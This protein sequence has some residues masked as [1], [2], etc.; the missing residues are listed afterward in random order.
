M[1]IIYCDHIHLKAEDVE[2]TA[3]WYRDRL[4]GAITYRGEFRGSPVVYVTFGAFNLV[5]YGRLQTDTEVPPV[6]AGPRYGI[7]HFGFRVDD[8]AAI[9]AEL[10][11]AGVTILE[12]PVTVR[13]GVHMAYIE[14]PERVRI[15]MVQRD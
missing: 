9:I 1:A 3:A 13:P 15:E 11:T 14:G 7:D 8:L 5:V 10:R 12:E 4:G 2:A 6:S